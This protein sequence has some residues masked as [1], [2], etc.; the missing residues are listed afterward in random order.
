MD[1]SATRIN[2]C[3]SR[4]EDWIWANRELIAEL[5]F[6]NEPK[7]CAPCKAEKKRAGSAPGGGFDQRPRTG[8]REKHAV[9]CSE[10]SKP[11]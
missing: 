1:S 7:R 6:T 11:A 9:V 10:C 2:S 8:Q 5:G 4:Y 3:P